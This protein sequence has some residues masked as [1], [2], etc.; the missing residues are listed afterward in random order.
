M[1]AGEGVLDRAGLVGVE[2]VDAPPGEG[3]AQPGVDARREVLVAGVAGGHAAD[4]RDETVGLVGPLHRALAGHHLPERQVESGVP[5]LVTP[6]KP[7]L[8]GHTGDRTSRPRTDQEAKVRPALRSEQA[9]A[10]VLT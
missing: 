1:P 5:L 10:A 3:R 9:A 2:P 4:G 6:G 8:H 7:R